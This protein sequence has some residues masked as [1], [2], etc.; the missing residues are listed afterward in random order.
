MKRFGISR[1]LVSYIKRGCESILRTAELE[2][3]TLNK[4]TIRKLQFRGVDKR[5]IDF[6]SL[7]RS[8]NQPITVLVIQ[9]SALKI[10]DPLLK[11]ETDEL[12]KQKLSNLSHLTVG[13]WFFIKHHALSSTSL[14][15]E[16]GSAPAH[17]FAR[18]LGEFREKLL[19]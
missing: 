2:K 12:E 16:V 19:Q 7:A 13:Q 5:V 11:N 18:D 17:L 10:R 3:K 9:Q 1:R 6:V 15:G 8:Y 4:K 14:H